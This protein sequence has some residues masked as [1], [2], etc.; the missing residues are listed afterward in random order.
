MPR[1][2]LFNRMFSSASARNRANTWVILTPHR[3]FPLC[4]AAFFDK[5]EHNNYLDLC[6]AEHILMRTT[7]SLK[8]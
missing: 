5:Q 6:A 8:I 3:A 1:R 7:R 2:F 4:S